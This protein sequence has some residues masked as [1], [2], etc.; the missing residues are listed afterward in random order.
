MHVVPTMCALARCRAEG[1]DRWPNSVKLS[2]SLLRAHSVRARRT[3]HPDP[4]HRQY[5]VCVLEGIQSL[6][7]CACASTLN[8]LRNASVRESKVPYSTELR[9]SWKHRTGNNSLPISGRALRLYGFVRRVW[10]CGRLACVQKEQ[11]LPHDPLAPRWLDCDL[12]T[13]SHRK[14]LFA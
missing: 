1:R 8:S 2:S 6:L 12:T 4:L 3:H 14:L 5:S 9:G 10:R 11:A 7:E 13:C